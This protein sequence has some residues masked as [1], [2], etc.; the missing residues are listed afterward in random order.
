MSEI[1]NNDNSLVYEVG[2][3][4]VPTIPEENLAEAVSKVV[5]SINKNGGSIV[6]EEF[7]KIRSLSYE[8]KKRVETKYLAFNK[9]YFGWIKFETDPP[10]ILQ[11]EKEIKNNENILRFLIIKTV[12]ENTLHT[13]KIPIFKKEDSQREARVEE[14]LEKPKASEE[15]I[16]KSIDELLVT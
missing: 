7:P 13:P 11:I 5:E 2:Y 12:R 15:E 3:H 9:A 4:L 1:K 6:S 14:R 10:S 8:V 16:D